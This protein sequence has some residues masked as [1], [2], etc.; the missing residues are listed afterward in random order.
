MISY[1]DLFK[2]TVAFIFLYMILSKIVK[3]FQ[4][5]IEKEKF[6]KKRYKI[7]QLNKETKNRINKI[8]EKRKK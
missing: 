2:I 5:D 3:I 8:N 4:L 1:E 6:L 7:Q